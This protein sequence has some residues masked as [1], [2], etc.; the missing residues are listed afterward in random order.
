[1]LC[2]NNIKLY[3][4]WCGLLIYN[5][6][7]NKELL[8]SHEYRTWFW[9]VYY[10]RKLFDMN[11]IR[12]SQSRVCVHETSFGNFVK[13]LSRIMRPENAVGH[14]SYSPMC[15]TQWMHS[16]VHLRYD[17]PGRTSKQW[18]Y[19]IKLTFLVQFMDFTAVFANAKDRPS[20][21]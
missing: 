16:D 1:M 8:P 21:L 13:Y 6:I 7:S 20:R 9:N 11:P 14:I 2:D 17:R 5:K 12:L 19:T 18:L 3:I 15:S 4:E 10:F